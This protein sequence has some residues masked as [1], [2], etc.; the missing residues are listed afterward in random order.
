MAVGFGA[1]H[2]DPN[3]KGGLIYIA[4]LAGR[5][6]RT[7]SFEMPSIIPIYH[8]GGNACSRLAARP[9][10]RTRPQT[11]CML[12]GGTLRHDAGRAGHTHLHHGAVEQR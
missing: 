6:L 4:K 7:A 2:P 11:Y 5:H 9:F 12:G 3:S 10:V 8:P 1:V